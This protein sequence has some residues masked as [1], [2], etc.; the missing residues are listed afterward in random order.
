M[1]KTLR[2]FKFA[3]FIFIL[4]PVLLLLCSNSLNAAS[5]RMNYLLRCT[6]C[7]G[8]T[9]AGSPPNV[10]TLVGELGRMLS[11]PQMRE[12]LLRI[13]G[14]SQAL[15]SDSELADVM[16]WMLEEFNADTLPESFSKYTAA[17]IT[18]SR[19]NVMA[20]PLKYRIEF[21]GPYSD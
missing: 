3:K 12:Y 10:P 18:R 5:P 13:P 16:N 2:H 7:H 15:L 11:V 4:M 21:W 19:G 9:G 6:G 1:I 14:A 20:D 17:E 8:A